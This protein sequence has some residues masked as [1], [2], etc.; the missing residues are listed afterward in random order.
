ME[1]VLGLQ[2]L[3]SDKNNAVDFFDSTSSGDACTCSTTSGSCQIT[4]GFAPGLF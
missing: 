4:R 3:Q 1:R 2:K